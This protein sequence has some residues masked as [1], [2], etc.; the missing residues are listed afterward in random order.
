MRQPEHIGLLETLN[1]FGIRAAYMQ[2]F[3]Q[4]LDDEGLPSNENRIEF[5]LPV[6]KNL[7]G[8]KL[9]SIRLKNDVDFKRQGPKPTLCEPRAGVPLDA[10]L[11]KYPLQLNWY[12]K[13]QFQQSRGVAGAVERGDLH[14]SRLEPHHLAFMDMDRI[15]F[16]LQEYKNDKS[17]YNLNLPRESIR[18]LLSRWDWY[19]LYIPAAEME[20]NRFDRVRRWEDV[21]IA[22]LKKYCD[23]LYKHRKQEWEADYLEYRELQES[24]PN[25]V[26]EYRLMIEQSAEDIKNNLEA[27]KAMITEGRFGKDWSFGKLDALCFGQHLYQP[28]LHFKSDLV[29]VMPVSL[30][31]G[32]MD[33]VCDLRKYFNEKKEFFENRELYLLRNMSRGRGIGFLKRAI[34]T[35]ILSCGCWWARSNM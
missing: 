6:I 31:D 30:N 28:L 5:I 21:A 8:K 14:E 20:F 26:Q 34:F 18:A 27:L 23:R 7:G 35:R 32:E 33:F 25:F 24:D 16:A 1:I 29:E 17:W 22:L 19:T 15:Y 13:I 2:Q 11:L 3:K 9:T 4:Y 12:P 10:P